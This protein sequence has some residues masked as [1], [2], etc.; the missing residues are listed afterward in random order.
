[1]MK[2][3]VLIGLSSM[4]VLPSIAAAQ[5]MSPA[6]HAG[7]PVRYQAQ[8]NPA[9]QQQYP[10]IVPVAGQ[11]MGANGQI[12]SPAPQQVQAQGQARAPQPAV[13]AKPYKKPKHL[14][15]S[16][17]VGASWMD[18]SEI[19]NT[20]DITDPATPTQTELEDQTY[21][22]SLALGYDLRKHKIPLRTELSFTYRPELDYNQNETFVSA[23]TPTTHNSTVGVRS[24]MA[25]VYYDLQLTPKIKPFVGGG[26][27]LSLQSIEGR[28]AAHNGSFTLDYEGGN[29]SFSWNLM[30][31]LAYQLTPNISLEGMYKY[32][33]MGEIVW[34]SEDTVTAFELTSEKATDHQLLVGAKYHF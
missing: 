20:S 14:Y 22:F 30:A 21:S 31:G 7:Y 23:G 2:K 26:L 17:H 25:N 12:V 16:A 3:I 24:L 9:Y 4:I 34:N 15:V 5:T 10:Q 8:Y 13:M 28:L 33:D 32:S 6:R 19:T 18:I 27:G 1:M 11:S 29:T